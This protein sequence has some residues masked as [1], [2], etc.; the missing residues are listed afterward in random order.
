MYVYFLIFRMV[1][2]LAT[3]VTS[4][5]FITDKLDGVWDR[6]LIAGISVT[7]LLVAHVITQS[8]IMVIQCLEVVFYAAYF[9]NAENRGDNVT[10]IGLLTLLG[11]AGMLF[12]KLSPFLC[13]IIIKK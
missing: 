10:V 6:T 4:T 7:E 2:F 3:L 9:F 12:G 5:I 11:F 8:V 1:F 13:T